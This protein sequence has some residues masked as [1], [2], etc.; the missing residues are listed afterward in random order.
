MAAAGCRARAAQVAGGGADAG[1]GD[2]RAAHLAVADQSPRGALE[3][4]AQRLARRPRDLCARSAPAAGPASVRHATPRHATPRTHGQHVVAR[5][6]ELSLPL[7]G[8]YDDGRHYQSIWSP[9]VQLEAK[10][11]QSIKSD[12]Q[13]GG[14]DVRWDVGLNKKHLVYFTLPIAHDEFKAR[15]HLSSFTRIILPD[16]YM[17]KYLGTSM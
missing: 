3:G 4:A 1:A 11:D 13:K 2:G 5:L 17:Y 6:L 9:L 15:V 7:I 14:I 8:S 16:V 10:Y 12:L